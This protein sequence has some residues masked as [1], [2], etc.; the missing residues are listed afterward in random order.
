MNYQKDI[1]ELIT[2]LKTE[3]NKL[4]QER[5]TCSAEDRDFVSGQHDAM[6]HALHLVIA[7]LDAHRG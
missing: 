2:E 7:Y 1:N 4:Y 6:G 5:E 3:T